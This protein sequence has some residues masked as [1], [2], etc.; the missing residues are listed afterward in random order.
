MK[1]RA[2]KIL[3]KLIGNENFLDI[4]RIKNLLKYRKKRYE[5]KNWVGC[6]GKK[7]TK[8]LK[9][10]DDKEC[11]FLHIPKAAGLSITYSLFGQMTG[12]HTTAREYRRIFGR[13]FN[14][15]YKFTVVRNPYS[16][17]VS[18]YTFLK[19]GG[20]PAF[21]NDKWFKKNILN[22]YDGFDSFV[23]NWLKPSKNEW[24]MPHFRPQKDFLEIDGQIRVDEIGYLEKIKSVY[25]KVSNKLNIKCK[26]EKR[27]K[28]KNESYSKFLDNS[29]VLRR[30]EEVYSKDFEAFDYDQK[31]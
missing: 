1:K 18:A 23:L 31:T 26:L 24:V 9:P 25:K 21:P 12:G 30:I 27:N 29:R 28:G 8:S 3:K 19:N 15:Y 11:I 14:R 2:K 16:R 10:F 7:Y 13:D 5:E 17:V 22:K 4:E 6:D 20:H